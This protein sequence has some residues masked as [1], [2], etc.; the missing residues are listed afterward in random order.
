MPAGRY[1]IRSVHTRLESS[2]SAFAAWKL[3]W[4]PQLPANDPWRPAQQRRESLSIRRYPD[5]TRSRPFP[6]AFCKQ[7]V[8]GSIP[9]GS[10]ARTVIGGSTVKSS[11]SVQ[12]PSIHE[13]LAGDHS[14]ALVSERADRSG[15]AGPHLRPLDARLSFGR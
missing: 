2:A 6:L 1:P 5:S 15:S 10:I 4:K 3:L 14:S 12:N 11:R 8:T 13:S 9:V 7:E